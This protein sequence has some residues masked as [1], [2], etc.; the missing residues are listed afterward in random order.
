MPS[1]APSAR[2]FLGVLALWLAAA[3]LLG[4]TGCVVA[5]VPPLP[6]V[7]IAVITI[8]LV[9]FGVGHAGFRAWLAVVPLR[10]IVAIH[11]TRFV[12]FA[13]LALYARGALPFEFAVPGGIGDIIVAALA[14]NLLILVPRLE[15]RRTLLM[16]W[17][18]LGLLDILFVVATATRLALADPSSMAALLRFPLSLVPTFLV[19]IVVASHLLVFWRLRRRR[20]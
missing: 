8:A 1:T 18:A 20:A 6:Q 12:G 17:N 3:A 11:L 10:A 14:V 9:L 4:A 7:M 16:A 13:F 15:S 5:L 19:P 2:P